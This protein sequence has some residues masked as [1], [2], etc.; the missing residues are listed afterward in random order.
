MKKIT[1]LF[2]LLGFTS[3]AQLTTD[4]SPA[5]ASGP[6][7]LFFDKEGTPLASYS[8]TIYAHI[9]LTVNGAD[10]QYVIGDWGQNDVQP[11][12]AFVSGTTYKLELT[13]DLYTY[14]GVPEE[15]TITKICVVFRAAAGSPQSVD[16][17]ANVGSFQVNMTTPVQNSTALLASGTNF[18]IAAT[19][20]GGNAS[21]T[22]KANG[23]VV[24]TNA[25]TSSYSYIDTVTT[26][27]NYELSV[28]QG[29]NTITKYFSVV[30]IP[31]N[32]TAAMP[33]GLSDGINYHADDDT[34]A[35]LV[36]SAPGKDF[37]YVAGSFNNW[38]PGMNDAMKTDSETGK[39]FLELTGLTP[40]E[41]YSYQYWVVDEVP[42]VAGTPKIVKTA[43]PFSTLVLSPYDDPWIPES[44]Y[45]DLPAYP[46]G[47]EREVTVL[48]TGQEEYDWQVADFEKPK[49]ED[50]VIYEVLVR[51]FDEHRTYQDLIDRIDYFTG[52]GINAIELMPVMEYEGN[53][54]WGYNTAFHMALD[55][56]YGPADKLKELVDV[57]HQNG[58]AVILDIALNHAFG[59]NPMA[60]MWMDDPDGDGWGGPSTENPYFN[61]MAMHAYNVGN[62]FN[63]QQ[64]LTQ[65]Y[66]KRVVKHWIEEFHIDGFRWDLTKGFTQ[67]CP[68]D[69]DCTNSYQQDRVD[70][71]KEYVDYSW[72][73]DPTHYA[74]FEHLGNDNEEKEWANYKLDEGKGVMMWGKMTDPYNQLTMGYGT[75]NNIARVGHNAHAGFQGKRVVGY[76]ESHDEERIMYKN[77]EFGNSAN[78]SH[79]VKNLDVAL[80]R[81][82][83]MGAML[84]MVP[85][86]K[87]IWHFGELGWDESIFTC[88]NGTVNLPGGTDGDCK[89]DTKPQP[90][91]AEGWIWQDQREAIYYSWKQM[92][93]IKKEEPVF[94]GNYVIEP[95]A[96]T[97]LTPKIYVTDN[98]LPEGELSSVVVLSNFNVTAINVVPNFPE[99]G[100]WYNLMDNTSIEVTNT[101]A[102]IN[103]QPGE[104]RIYGNQQT[105]LGNP[106]FETTAVALYPNPAN[107]MF[108]L[109]R[110]VEKVEIYNMAGQLVKSF[111]GTNAYSAYNISSL[112]KGIYMVKV[113]DTQNRQSAKKL[114]KE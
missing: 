54:S 75:N 43:D 8:G 5:I 55:K 80:S 68:G 56:F 105:T 79:D 63:H 48:Q 86:P 111:E 104:F 51:D 83:A 78:P 114:I 28:T 9:G 67:N 110:A 99:A 34:K 53:E 97:S 64:E 16:L 32:I 62:D 98:T 88:N 18:N 77:V 35:T 24:N 103:L 100:T 25:S 74:I 19:N 52:L 93:N 38:I 26:N 42:N 1:V 50:L 57:C 3:F 33:G 40:G 31:I 84:F 72:S 58:I 21:Y 102:P 87:M 46:V 65:E 6:V 12:L 37:V 49:K 69:E 47:Q 29:D 45:P 27:R 109:N 11:A 89:L 60:R 15:E 107:D 94:E 14:F 10:W 66:T 106:E 22:L 101:V 70:I 73:I 76:A 95:A 41:T 85:G 30:V 81:M 112:S 7:T 23:E 17:F 113:T 39:F 20:T 13:P 96:G 44:S 36:L 4:P 82:P 108:M 2:L 90:Q 91:W 61:T 92:I 71:L 59:R